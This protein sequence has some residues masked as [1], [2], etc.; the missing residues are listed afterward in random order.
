MQYKQMLD[1][2]E[3]ESQADLARLL[4]VSR[5]KV[6]QILNLLKLEGEIREFILS[7]DDTDQWLEVLTERKLRVWVK[8][9]KK[10]QVEKFRKMVEEF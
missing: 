6:T 4:G 1:G 3:A 2:G 8:L 9:P 10:R 7:L 5:A